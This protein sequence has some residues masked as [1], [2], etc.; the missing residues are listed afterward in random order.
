V[1]IAAFVIT[2]G[3]FAM[4]LWIWMLA[5]LS[6]Y[7]LFGM[8]KKVGLR[9][10]TWAGYGL[11]TA[12]MI[13]AYLDPHFF[14][15]ASPVVEGLVFLVLAGCITELIFRRVW[16][17]K[18]N[19]MATARVVVF[20]I[21]TFTFIFLLREGHNGIVNFLFSVLV[22]W[23]TDTMALFGGR[24]LGRTPLSGISPNKTIEGSLI[25]LIAALVIGWGYL[26]V[27][28]VFFQLHLN[29][30]FYSI[31]ALGIGII[32]Q[33]GDLHESLVK[34]HFGVKDSSNLLPGHGGIY[35]RADSTLFV[36]PLSFFLF[37]LR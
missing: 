7:E 31:F 22:I 33:I 14:I 13:S 30:M 18:S 12:A 5:I 32:S 16:I 26:A 4:W 6:A 2:F 19:L 21:A 28:A 34:R 11:I 10:Y 1:G 23:T 20:V 15:W 29:A 27:L 17:P 36:A 25:G 24:L 3:G 9:P 37:N 35:D 8:M